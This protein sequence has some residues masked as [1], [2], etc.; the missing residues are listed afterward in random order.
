[1]APPTRVDA[2]KELHK[3]LRLH[4]E[5]HRSQIETI[6]NSFDK[7]K[8]EECL[9][10]TSKTGE[11]LKHDHDTS[12]GGGFVCLITP[13]WNLE[14]IAHG[15]PEYMLNILRH[16]ATKSLTEQLWEGANG[17]RGGEQALS[18]IT[19]D[20]LQ[21]KE[22][23]TTT[24]PD[25]PVIFTSIMKGSL[26]SVRAEEWDRDKLYTSF[27]DGDHYG[28]TFKY[29]PQTFERF[30]PSFPLCK[31]ESI[32]W[33]KFRMIKFLT[34]MVRRI[35]AEGQA[36]DSRELPHDSP[37]D[38]ASLT[39][40]L[41]TLSTDDKSIPKDEIL[42]Y[43]VASTSDQAS[44]LESCVDSVYND[45]A[46][47]TGAF[48]A[49]FDSR[50][51]LVPEVNGNKWPL[52]TS[53]YFSPAF[54]GAVHEAV[55]ESAIWE[56]ISAL[57]ELLQSTTDKDHR[58]MIAYD[59]S[60][61]C[62]LEYR[63]SQRNLTRHVQTGAASECFYRTSEV[64][65][66]AGNARV[67]M[68][69]S[70][71]E[72]TIFRPQ[73]HYLLR[74]CHQKTTP[75]DAIDWPN[76]LGSL[77]SSAP[78][79]QQKLRVS[80]FEALLSLASITGVIKDLSSI[81]DLPVG[82]ESHPKGF[83]SRLQKAE[84]QLNEIGE[85][86]DLRKYIWPISNLTDPTVAKAALQGLEDAAQPIMGRT[87]REVYSDLVSETLA[88]LEARYEKIN[89]LAKK[90]TASDQQWASSSSQAT[91]PS[92]RVPQS[93]RRSKEKTRPSSAPTLTAPPE[94]AADAE[95][96]AETPP[97]VPDVFQVSRST[98]EVFNNI[99]NRSEAH[100]P[101][102]WDDFKSAMAELGFAIHP[103]FGSVYRFIP[104]QSMNTTRP[105]TVHDPHKSK[106]EGRKKSHLRRRL[107]KVYEWEI[108]N[109]HTR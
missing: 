78:E 101:V 68:R 10:S 107:Q 98:W 4:F 7:K 37:D 62:F 71:E 15:G 57:T 20:L 6:W 39:A 80:E 56:L 31:G 91:S 66:D 35:L 96:A 76:R 51:G 29:D 44:W 99:L 28:E 64:L 22:K 94:R 33:R 30:R 21:G 48:N 1:M 40:T 13:E 42:P 52:H 46:V 2:L 72:L 26:R 27:Q 50:P 73:L 9:S 12:V 92:S 82:S 32:L 19:V 89:G 49:W 93:Q 43:L 24:I 100:G 59:L 74:L 41:S 109:F 79:L 81:I 45:P 11:I 3:D 102:N 70:P 25:Y 83:R 38:I 61:I 54:F 104:P 23:L 88:N 84:A 53:K 97:S 16:R 47:L 5:L 34:Y 85:K 8:R 77:H 75:S 95:A 108:E 103:R 87:I 86:V 69:Y 105:L 63:R 90:D 36:V 58:K 65:D 60:D 18:Q 14:D 17:Q 106:I 55:K 67:A